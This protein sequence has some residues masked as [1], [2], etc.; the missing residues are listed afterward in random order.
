LL[1]SYYLNKGPHD[2]SF[3]PYRK[4]KIIG[5]QDPIPDTVSG[6]EEPVFKELIKRRHACLGSLQVSSNSHGSEYADYGLL[7]CDGV[8]LKTL[9]FGATVS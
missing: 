3:Q 4:L 8:G 2:R 9:M 1:L 6:N 7:G 5:V